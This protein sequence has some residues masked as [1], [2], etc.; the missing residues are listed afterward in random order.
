MATRMMAWWRIWHSRARARRRPGHCAAEGGEAR[1]AGDAS[2]LDW[3]SGRRT[4]E[5]FR[6]S[7][8]VR[9]RPIRASRYATADR[10][11]H[12]ARSTAAPRFGFTFAPP[13]ATPPTAQRRPIPG[14]GSGLVKFRIPRERRKSSAYR[15]D[16]RRRTPRA[17]RVLAQAAAG[18]VQRCRGRPALPRGA[19]RA[20]ARRGAA[21]PHARTADRG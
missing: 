6:T 9:D 4:A 14:A 20:A 3:R 13:G 17:R 8:S 12:A 16:R 2:G 1:G 11:H 21:A 15:I 10:T 5:R 7:F 19:R 18:K